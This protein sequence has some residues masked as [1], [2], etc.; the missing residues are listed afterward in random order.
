VPAESGPGLVA[1]VVLRGP[2]KAGERATA[3]T[4]V[5]SPAIPAASIASRPAEICTRSPN[6]TIPSAI[7]ASG[8]AAAM[9]GSE[10]RSGAALN[11]FCISQMPTMPAPARAQ[12]GQRVNSIGS[13]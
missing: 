10:A 9:A 7:P 8:S 6:T 3:T 5:I 4:P 12:A 2:A 11:A 1:W 13:E